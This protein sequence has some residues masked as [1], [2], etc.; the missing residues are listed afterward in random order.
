[1][2]IVNSIPKRII[3]GNSNSR[4]D[5]DQ[6]FTIRCVCSDCVRV[7]GYLHSYC[8]QILIFTLLGALNSSN[9]SPEI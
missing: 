2:I 4:K 3:I 8:I 5:K 1:M 9:L 7:C 6:F